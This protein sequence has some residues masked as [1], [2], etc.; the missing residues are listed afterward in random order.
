MTPLTLSELVLLGALLGGLGGLLGIGGG[1][2]QQHAQGTALVMVV[3]NV[4]IAQRR[5]NRRTALDAR[6]AWSRA[7]ECF[8]AVRGRKPPPKGLVWPWWRPERLAHRL[9]DRAL[10]LAFAG[11]YARQRNPAALRLA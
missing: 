5:Y 11:S 3:P 1:L 6:I 10:R 8:R 2:D 7:A 4:A 9:P